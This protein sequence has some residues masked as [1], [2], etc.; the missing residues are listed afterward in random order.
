MIPSGPAPLEPTSLTSLPSLPTVRWLPCLRASR[1]AAGPRHSAGVPARASASRRP[2]RGF[3]LR[4]GW[5]WT[6]QPSPPCPR[7]RRGSN[8]EPASRRPPAEWEQR[9]WRAPPGVGRRHSSRAREANLYWPPERPTVSGR[10]C[11]KSLRAAPVDIDSSGI[12]SS[13]GAGGVGSRRAGAPG[14]CE[15]G[16]G[17]ASDGAPWASWS[18]GTAGLPGPHLGGRSG[19][20]RLG[21]EPGG[22]RPGGWLGHDGPAHP[23]SVKRGAK[24]R[25]TVRRGRRGRP[26]LPGLPGPHLGGCSG[27]ARLGRGPGGGRPVGDWRPGDRQASLSRPAAV[28][29]AACQG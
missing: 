8:R 20:A 25:P 18:A 26:G 13:G 24:A 16:G 3:P 1:A 11:L 23:E 19:R 15:T 21:W 9:M 14:V 6:R 12:D 28:H 27:R 17:G 5:G 4:C 22:G 2:P 10:T 29:P 7:A